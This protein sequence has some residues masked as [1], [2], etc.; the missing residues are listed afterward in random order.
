MAMTGAV[1]NNGWLCMQYEGHDTSLVEIGIDD[2]WYPAYLDYIDGV[3]IAKIR[4]PAE[5]VRGYIHLRINGLEVRAD[6]FM[7]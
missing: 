7:G 5:L 2:V 3:R 4:P 1:L 6:R